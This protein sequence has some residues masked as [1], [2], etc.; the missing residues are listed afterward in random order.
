MFEQKIDR[1]VINVK[2]SITNT[3][4]TA[5]DVLEKSPGITMNRQN[6][7]IAVNGK[8]GVMVMMN[9][10][11]NYMPME[12]LVQLL[13][14]TSAD[15]IEKIEL[16]TTPPSKYDAEGNAGYIN[17]V[18]INNPY[19]GISGSYFLNAGYGKKEL[20][21][22]GINFNYRSAKINLYGNYS[23]SYVHHI[24]PSSGFTQFKGQVI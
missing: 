21:G 22:A 12:A 19:S 5:L 16:I 17:I 9:G 4:G 6:N 13:S 7:T 23:A 15:N 14:A 8:N 20:G 11:I 2:N 24:Q 18:M 10:K 1:M 3:G